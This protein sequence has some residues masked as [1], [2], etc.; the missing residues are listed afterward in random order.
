MV[1]WTVKEEACL[2]NN[3]HLC[4]GK[5][6]QFLRKAR[7][8]DKSHYDLSNLQNGKQEHSK[9]KAETADNKSWLVIINT[10]G[11]E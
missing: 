8:L 6:Y 3:D 7:A 10:E 9:F 2:N 5:I 1:S 11:E 4:A